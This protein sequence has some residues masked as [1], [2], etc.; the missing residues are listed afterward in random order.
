LDKIEGGSGLHT[1]S[2]VKMRFGAGWDGPFGDL[3]EHYDSRQ[4]YDGTVYYTSEAGKALAK[5]TFDRAIV[6][7]IHFPKLSKA[8]D[9][10]ERPA[11][12]KVSV[13]PEHTHLERIADPDT[14]PDA[15][16][17]ESE[18]FHELNRGMFKVE[19]DGIDPETPYV[20][21]ALPRI[22]MRTRQEPQ[23]K[24]S[25][26]LHKQVKRTAYKVTVIH[27]GHTTF[28]VPNEHAQ[29]WSDWKGERPARARFGTVTMGGGK[30]EAGDVLPM[31]KLKFFNLYI[32]HVHDGPENTEIE[33][34][35]DKLEVEHMPAE[36]DD[37]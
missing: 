3:L 7:S 22:R 27:V 15:P 14:A 29:S 28:V 32:N 19:I 24:W 10:A 20:T 6:K 16:E 8:P 18:H 37:H 9:Q 36:V 1:P 34:S 25:K 35:A 13:Q 12:F 17:P 30:N 26:K 31:W 33:V 4:R 2:A 21:V 11:V 23:F 5:L